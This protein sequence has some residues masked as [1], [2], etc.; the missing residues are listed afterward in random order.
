MRPWVRSAWSWF[1]RVVPW[2]L[3]VLVLVLV[4]RQART[5]DWPAVGQAL[6]RLPPDRLAAAAGLALLSHGLYASFDL[7]G[8]RL[9]G[10]RLSAPRTL[11]T[12][13]ISYAFNLNAGSLVGGFALRLRLYTR[14][15]LSASTVAQIIAHSMATNWLGYLW[16]DGAVLLWAP[17]RLSD[18]WSLPDP[19]LRAIGLAMLLAALAYPVLCRF[20]RP[21]RLAWRGQPLTLASAPLAVWQLMAG[22]A[23]WLLIGATVWTL[24]GGHVDYPTVLG[25]LLL[26]ALAGVLTHVPAGLGVL[27]AVFVATLGGRL[28]V[29]EVLATVLAYRA[30]YYLLPLALALPAYAL[31]EAVARHCNRAAEAPARR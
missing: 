7:I 15:G 22:G 9:S 14:W 31:S 23:N 20:A 10:H 6:Q 13:A 11:G 28:P 18:G 3:A 27:E 8:R 12:A 19:A 21:R 30:T 17:P 26:A 2:A 29:A 16:V 4:V 5:V 1:K 24:F 25:A